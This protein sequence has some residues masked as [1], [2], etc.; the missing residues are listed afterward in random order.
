MSVLQRIRVERRI[1][2]SFVIAVGIVLIAPI[3]SAGP[4]LWLYPKD[5][6]P[7]EGGHVVPPGPFTL[8]IENR[9][10]T[11]E[12]NTAQSVELVIA[13]ED[14]AAVT[15]LQLSYDGGGPMDLDP[16]G[17][18]EGAP[19]L[20]C[21]EK[22]MP[23]HGE[24]PAAFTTVTVDE[25]AGIGDLVGGQIVEIEVVV[26]GDESLRV[27]FDA[28][29]TG[30]K[31]TGQGTRCFDISNPPGHD[32]TV[33]NGR[34]GEDSCGRV[35]I[36]KTTEAR[37]VE[38]GDIATFTIEVTNDGTCD[39]TEPVLQDLVPAVEDDEGALYPAFQWT[40]DSFPV[41]NE[42]DEF[43]LEWPLPTLAIGNTEVVELVVEFDEPFAVGRR[44]KNRACIAAPEL[45]KPRCASAIV[46]V[47]ISDDDSGWAGPGFWCHATRWVIEDR[48]N[49]P[50]ASEEL[51]AWLALIDED[52]GVYSE[53]YPILV[54]DDDAASLETT[55]ELLCSPQFAAGP[56]DRLARHLLTLW[57]NVV[58]ERLDRGLMLGELCLGD[59]ML[60]EGVD[61]EMTVG[62]LLEEVDAGLAAG[63]EDEQLNYWSEIVDAVNNA[64]ISDD[65]ECGEQRNLT[66]S[67]RRGNGRDRGSLGNLHGGN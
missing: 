22:P 67:Q 3:V 19:I 6:G 45:K 26:E 39:L 61:P 53:Y 12:D 49:V 8:V 46:M 65:G 42:I 30:Y 36:S 63:D 20:P 43:L 38:F 34:G 37:S 16:S 41:P 33:A 40:G 62:E 27:H 25:I 50:V 4:Q 64:S 1:R 9:G 29:A 7:R 10:N 2:R 57:L 59:E 51:L 14:P 56:A 44:I 11:S 66:R 23:R 35:S 32:V 5:A 28:M 47:G 55:A 24:Y 52:S 31:T 17:W 18:D 48:P 54:T 58:S 13:A 60:P 21:S 15:L